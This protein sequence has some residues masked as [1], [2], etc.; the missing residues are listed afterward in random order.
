MP[1]KLEGKVAVVTGGGQGIGKGIATAFRA[2]GM[3]GLIAFFILCKM[4]SQAS[5]SS[6]G[7]LN[8]SS[9]EPRIPRKRSEST[10]KGARQKLSIN[11]GN[12]RSFISFTGLSD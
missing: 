11:G 2:P 7:R 1:K 9:I 3:A 10:S 6:S 8:I 5:R 4:V 12:P